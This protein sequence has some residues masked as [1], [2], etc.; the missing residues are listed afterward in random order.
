[1]ITVCYRAPLQALTH[2]GAEQL[3]ACRVSDVLRHIRKTHGREA[4]KLARSMLIVIDGESILLKQ[5]FRT[6]VSDGQTLS[7]LPVCG[8]G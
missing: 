5:A 3:P 1:M 2:T 8:G 7:F 6:G 4:E